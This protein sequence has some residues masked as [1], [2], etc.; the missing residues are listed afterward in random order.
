MSFFLQKGKIPRKKQENSELVEC[1]DVVSMALR[2][3]KFIEGSTTV[4]SLQAD[5]RDIVFTSGATE[6]NNLAIKGVAKFR[7]QSG[8]NHIITLQTVS[9]NSAKAH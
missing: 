9:S 4:H 7:K 3:P 8:K 6:S 1:L 5:P 2:V